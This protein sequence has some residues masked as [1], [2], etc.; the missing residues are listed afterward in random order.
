[1]QNLKAYF[2]KKNLVSQI[3]NKFSFHNPSSRDIKDLI[4]S[5]PEETEL[6]LYLGTEH[7][8]SNY[9]LSEEVISRAMLNYVESNTPQEAMDRIYEELT[10]LSGWFVEFCGH[11]MVALAE[12]HWGDYKNLVVEQIDVKSQGKIG[13][14]TIPFFLE[15]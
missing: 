2:A 7:A 10:K 3:R 8:N 5:M 11:C 12:E 6:Y 13:E 4:D 15:R 14:F 9:Y 1:M